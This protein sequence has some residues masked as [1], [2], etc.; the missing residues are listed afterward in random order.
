VQHA[1][2]HALLI[3][4]DRLRVLRGLVISDRL[5]Q[6]LERRVR[7]DLQRLVAKAS[8]AFLRTFSSPPEPRSMSKGALPIARAWPMTVSA[9]PMAADIGSPRWPSSSR[10]TPTCSA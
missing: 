10:R 1:R 3:V 8:L 7:G 9:T 4:A 6:L 5:S 2:Q